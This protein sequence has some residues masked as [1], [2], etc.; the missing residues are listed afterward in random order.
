MAGFQFSTRIEAL[1]S[2]DWFDVIQSLTELDRRG[3][4]HVSLRARGPEESFTLSMQTGASRRDKDWRR[5]SIRFVLRLS[6]C[7]TFPQP[8]SGAGRCHS[9]ALGLCLSEPRACADFASPFR[10]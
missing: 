5:V 6:E 4:P 7:R 1:F 8:F 3:F 9:A 2:A 10:W